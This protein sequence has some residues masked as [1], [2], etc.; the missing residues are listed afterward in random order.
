M[1]RTLLLSILLSSFLLFCPASFTHADNYQGHVAFSP[2]DLEIS[3]SNGYDVIFL[4]GAGY[5]S[6]PGAPTLPSVQINIV[7]PRSSSV[8]GIQVSSIETKELEGIYDL[9]PMSKPIHISASPEKNPFVKDPAIYKRNKNYPGVF[10]EVVGT[11]DLVG[12]DFVVINVHPVQYNPVTKKISFTTK[13]D[14][15]IDYL[16]AENPL[17]ETYNFSEKTKNYYYKFLKE[18]AINPEDV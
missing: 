3:R 8:Q 2:H 13:I 14:F 16:C 11:W 5:I 12:Q 15:V 17:Q 10:A 9:M 7:L 4:K 18:T 1:H 6:A